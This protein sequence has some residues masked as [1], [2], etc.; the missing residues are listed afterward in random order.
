MKRQVIICFAVLLSVCS[1]LNISETGFE[2]ASDN[3]PS[4]SI[5][6]AKEIFE[7]QY[8]AS[9]SKNVA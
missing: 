3:N 1:C 9:V 5:E 8:L 4:F 2:R 6:E 7:R